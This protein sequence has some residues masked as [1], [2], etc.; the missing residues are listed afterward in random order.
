MNKLICYTWSV[1]E[2]MLQNFEWVTGSDKDK[3]ISVAA[4]IGRKKI[5]W[6]I[7]KLRNLKF[8]AP[9]TILLST[10][11][12]IAFAFQNLRAIYFC[13]LVLHFSSKYYPQ[14]RYRYARNR[15]ANFYRKS[16]LNIDMCKFESSQ[17]DKSRV[18]SADSS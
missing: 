1:A 8:S 4:E 6:L 17:K 13:L 7:M 3:I 5:D 18:Q 11:L 9:Y 12:T 16:Y 2:Y 14:W 15:S 10:G